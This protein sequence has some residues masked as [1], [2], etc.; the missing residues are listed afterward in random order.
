MS[1]RNISDDAS[2]NDGR[3]VVWAIQDLQKA[4]EALTEQQRIAN[5]IALETLRWQRTAERGSY[6]GADLLWEP[7]RRNPD[8]NSTLHPDIAA[9]L[10]IEE[11]E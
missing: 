1:E 5:V 11:A 7:P 2:T 6:W 8:G 3:V 9:A 10:G 4:V